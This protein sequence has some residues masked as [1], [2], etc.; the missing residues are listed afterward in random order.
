MHISQL[1]QHV[2]QTLQDTFQ[3]VDQWFDVPEEVLAF[4][5]DQGWS[6]GQ[7]LDHI[8][9]TNHFLLM[10]IE[11]AADKARRNVNQLDLQ[12]LL[13]NPEFHLERLDQVG[14]HGAFSWVRPEHMEPNGVADLVEDSAK[15]QKSGGSMPAA[16]A[17]AFSGRRAVY[18]TTMTVNG[19]ERL[20]VYEYIY[21]LAMHAKR[22]LTQMQNNLAQF[23]PS[24]I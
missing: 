17:S 20:N 21:F 3:Q 19:L 8:S 22:H 14:Q 9:L 5:P 10:L 24:A 12:A 11:K 6:T 16:P 18:T 7:V 13:Q 2:E 23:R 1:I 15:D 4:Q